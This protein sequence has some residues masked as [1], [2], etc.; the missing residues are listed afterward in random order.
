MSPDKRRG[1][2]ELAAV[3]NFIVAADE[4]YQL[5]AF[6][7][8]PPPPPPLRSFDVGDNV[9]SMGS[10]SK[11]TGPGL[12]LGWFQTSA[13]AIGKLLA[14]GQIL[15]GGALNPV[16]AGVMQKAMESKAQVTERCT[17]SYAHTHTQTYVH[18]HALMYVHDHTHAH[19]YAHVRWTLTYTHVLTRTYSPTGIHN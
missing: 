2:C 10:F 7:S 19:L 15:S 5:L 3:H 1:L 12:R 14:N 16:V 13:A 6:P 4:A 8:S 17:R 9:V 11:I 18:G